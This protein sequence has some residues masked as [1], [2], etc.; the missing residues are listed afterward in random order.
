MA[1][2]R[3]RY[4]RR[5]LDQLRLP[6]GSTAV[7]LDVADE[8]CDDLL[9]VNGAYV[10]KSHPTG[11]YVT[12]F[13]ICNHLQQLDSAGI[14]H[15]CVDTYAAFDKSGGTH[16]STRKAQCTLEDL[17]RFRGPNFRTELAGRLAMQVHYLHTHAQVAHLDLKPG[18]VVMISARDPSSVRLIDMGLARP[19][20]DGS[21]T[22]PYIASAP[23]RPPEVSYHLMNKRYL[24]GGAASL[25]AIDVW[26]LGLM[27]LWILGGGGQDVCSRV[28]DVI[29]G[30]VR[31]GLQ[32]MD[33]D[34]TIRSLKAAKSV[35]FG[36]SDAPSIHE[37][38]WQL[39]VK[40]IPPALHALASRIGEVC[41]QRIPGRR[42]TA[43]DV[44]ALFGLQIVK[45]HDLP[46]RLPYTR[47]S[48]DTF[49]VLVTSLRSAWNSVFFTMFS[50]YITSPLSKG[51]S[52]RTADK[53]FVWAMHDH[54]EITMEKAAFTTFGYVA[55]RAMCMMTAAE[56]AVYEVTA[57]MSVRAAWLHCSA[58]TDGRRRPDVDQPLLVFYQMFGSLHPR[59]PVPADMCDLT[60]DTAMRRLVLLNDP[61]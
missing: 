31:H 35:A 2:L 51:R 61:E 11:V 24:D 59:L 19:L 8:D 52:P 9:L 25:T 15:G 32:V 30:S 10:L 26:S 7:P 54:P 40:T 56:T 22:T 50:S 23:Y 33:G 37:N 14:P 27:C 57:L 21:R 48:T 17:R 38:A 20:I 39:I 58:H 16:I 5:L 12:E 55:W 36:M 47:M 45:P 46:R 1:M 60:W 13:M 3:D 4:S 34:R 42:G 29:P 28:E 41:L 43:A 49:N 18:N 53:Y 6:P 44:C